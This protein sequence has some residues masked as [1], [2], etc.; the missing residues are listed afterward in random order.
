MA[1]TYSSY[2]VT[3]IVGGTIIRGFEQIAINT[4]PRWEF[5]HDNE[6]NAIRIE[7]SNR[8]FVEISVD[9]KQ[10]SQDQQ[11]LTGYYEAGGQVN[12]LIRDENGT[13]LFVAAQM[14]LE[15][16]STITK[17]V[18]SLNDNSWT[19]KGNFQICNVGGNS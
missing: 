14:S 8:R 13:D 1:A 4:N 2:D 16:P 3:L 10:T 15:L 11:I 17:A 9:M 5:D 19:L 6:G 7:Q 18:D 12:V